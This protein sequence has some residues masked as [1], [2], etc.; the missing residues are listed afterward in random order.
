MPEVV[1]AKW[2]QAGGFTGTGLPII[3]LFLDWTPSSCST[4]Q[5]ILL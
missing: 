1:S 5:G 3:G 4:Y 2:V